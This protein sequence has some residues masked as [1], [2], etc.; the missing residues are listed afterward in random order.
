MPGSSPG[1]L[2]GLAA[3]LCCSGSKKKQEVQA[4]KTVPDTSTPKDSNGA[5]CAAPPLPSGSASQTTDVGIDSDTVSDASSVATRP[6]P[7]THVDPSTL[8]SPEKWEEDDDGVDIDLAKLCAAFSSLEQ[9]S[10]VGTTSAGLPGPEA[11]SSASSSYS[12]GAAAAGMPM[13]FNSASK[14]RPAAPVV[15]RPIGQ[16]AAFSCSSS[17]LANSPSE[18]CRSPSLVHSSP[19]PSKGAAGDDQKKMA[20]WF[21]RVLAKGGAGS[22]GVIAGNGAF[23]GEDAVSSAGNSRPSRPMSRD[24]TLPPAAPATALPNSAATVAVTAA[25]LLAATSAGG[26]SVATAVISAPSSSAAVSVSAASASAY[27]GAAP[28]KTG[29]AVFKLEVQL[30]G[31]A[32]ST[33]ACGIDEDIEMVCKEFL[34]KHRLREVFLSPLI[35]H[36][37]LMMHMDKRADSVDVVDLI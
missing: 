24:A 8:S 26:A 6:E 25:P 12:N 11:S 34:A 4:T 32:L 13:G 35:T 29:T 17:S 21:E 3:L 36:V 14:A 28:F 31:E 23:G 19:S 7:V 30:G 16:N 1:C 37:E 18:E 20:A 33:L 2:R 9:S 10:M 5:G 22:A 15:S 27:V